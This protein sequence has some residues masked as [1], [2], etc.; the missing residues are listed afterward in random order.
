[1]NRTVTSYV[2]VILA[3][4]G[5]AFAAHSG[6]IP[7]WGPI[8]FSAYDSDGNGAVSEEEFYA[9]RAER[10]TARADEGRPLANVANAPQFSDFDTDGNGSLSQ[11]EL[12][13]GQ[14]ARMQQRG[15]TGM[16]PGAG[17]GTGMGP[18]AGGRGMGMGPGAGGPGGNMPTFAEFDLNGDG[19]LLAD[20]F[21]QAHA[22][23]ISERAQ[24]G[25]PMRGLSN[26]L[27]F[28]D[29]D[30][31]GNGQVTPEEFTAAQVRHRQ[32]MMQGGAK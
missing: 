18:G 30:G 27:Q 13:A 11:D 2:L 12:L 28:P 21:N 32:T 25:Y 7:D 26:M 22:Q 15:G 3:G 9:A 20:E 14:Q 16:G 17:G 24:Q 5:A 6:E 19:V 31:D 23:R 10:I 8:P 1:M 4:L 29:M